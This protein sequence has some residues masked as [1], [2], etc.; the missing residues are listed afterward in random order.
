MILR[1]EAV[2]ERLKELDQ[3]LSELAKYRNLAWEVFRADLSQ[4]W[5]IERGLLAAA[6][7]IFDIADHILAGHFA[8]YAETYEESLEGLHDKRVISPELYRQIRGLGGF[9]NILIHR[10]LNIDQREVF[11]HFG[12]G[13]TVFPEFAREILAWLDLQQD[14]QV[15]C[16]P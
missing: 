1:R 11:E 4:Q 16:E 5:I 13:L 12:K 10:Y 3:I 9:R 7:V 15:P 6:A 2:E 8:F 14:K